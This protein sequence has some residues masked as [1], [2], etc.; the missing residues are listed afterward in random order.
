MGFYGVLFRMWGFISAWFVF[1]R[2][3]PFQSVLDLTW[4]DT[5]VWSFEGALIVFEIYAIYLIFIIV[6]LKLHDHEGRSIFTK[7]VL[8]PRQ[9]LKALHIH[10]AMLVCFVYV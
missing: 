6:F 8:T 2:P 1:W 7:G 4:Q 5:L 9:H 3:A 10:H